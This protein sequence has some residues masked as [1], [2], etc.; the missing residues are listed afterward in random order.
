MDRQENKHKYSQLE[1]YKE[2]LEL[3]NLKRKT[4]IVNILLFIFAGL[5]LYFILGQHVEASLLIPSLF[6]VGVILFGNAMLVSIINDLYNNLHLAMYFTIIG[7]YVIS[8]SLVFV[9]QTPSIFTVLFLGYAITSI[10][11]DRKGMNLSSGLLFISSTF[12]V[13]QF[14]EFFELQN[15][16]NPQTTYIL[17]FVSVFI[18]LLALSSYILIKRKTFFYNQIASIKE[19]EIRNVSLLNQTEELKLKRSKDFSEYYQDL[20]VFSRELSQKIGVDSIFSRRLEILKILSQKS[21]SEIQ[22]M[23]PEFSLSEI[24]ELR[25]MEIGVNKKVVNLAIKAATPTGDNVSRKEI[26]SESQFKSFNHFY[27]SRYT[28]IISFAVF[29]TLLKVDKP[30]LKKLDEDTLKDV[31]YNSEYFYRMDKDIVDIY[32]KNYEVFDTI[33][34]DYLKGGW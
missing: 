34:S 31:I 17:I 23:F 19:S 12:F 4:M 3:E 1:I 28:K 10:Y 14:S 22:S 24:E 29:Y 18:L 33:V 21:N 13:I 25:N 11:Q 2:A 9:F 27:D 8:N 26:F 7:I 32:L 30:Y 6:M 5:M 16:T 15:G 20:E